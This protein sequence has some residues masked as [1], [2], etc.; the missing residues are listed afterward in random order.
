MAK[1]AIL[2]TKTKHDTAIRLKTSAFCNMQQLAHAHNSCYKRVGSEWSL[3]LFCACRVSAG[4]ANGMA[5]STM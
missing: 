3:K 2:T 4:S 1:K 5:V